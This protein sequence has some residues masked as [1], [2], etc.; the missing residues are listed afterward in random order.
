M[1]RRLGP[2]R[3]GI[4]GG[5]RSAVILGALALGACGADPAPSGLPPGPTSPKS[6]ATT[7]NATQP[8]DTTQSSALDDMFDELAAIGYA[9]FSNSGQPNALGAG[10][11]SHDLERSVPG[12]NLYTSIPF[13]S[14]VLIDADGEELH[15]W[16]DD[17][18]RWTRTRLLPD[19][20]L[21]V[22]GVCGPEDQRLPFLKRLHWDGSLAWSARINAHHD[23]DVLPDGRILVL[24]KSRRDRTGYSESG[25]VRD[26][27]LTMLS[28][29]GEVLDSRSISDMIDAGPASFRWHPAGEIPGHELGATA[30]YLHC[31]SVFWLSNA[32]EKAGDEWYAAGN[33]LLSSRHQSSLL[34]VNW[35]RGQL[36]W[37]FAEGQLQGQH[38]ASLLPSGNILL[39]DNGSEER[40]W[41]RLV[42]LQ[43]HSGRI[44][45][46]YKAD[47][48]E[49]FYSSGRGTVQSLRGGNLLVGNSA[50]G[51]AFEITREG[52]QVW[53]FFNPDVNEEGV[54]AALRIERY[55]VG[56]I[57]AILH[58]QE[59]TQD[60]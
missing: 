15:R 24:T 44:V 60:R 4:P 54:S 25:T 34:M 40:G 47:P 13:A 3:L 53:H 21:L 16:H 51:E 50:S 1:P 20:D 17:C 37:S 8:D 57:T 35:E 5:L 39:F 18:D 6:S 29:A 9:D 7:D 36:L 38:E 45:W 41:S 12:Y 59:T 33:V 27:E 19:G 49:A 28:P 48:P 43:P 52:E 14:A 32:H 55:P 23:L 58:Q 56:M 31:N 10:V 26:N 22:I 46:E 30:D 42:E 2:F 11:V